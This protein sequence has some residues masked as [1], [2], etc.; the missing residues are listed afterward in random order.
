M[1]RT[2]YLNFLSFVFSQFCSLNLLT[3]SRILEI[4]SSAD[5]FGFP[6]NGILEIFMSLKTF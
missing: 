5:S 4:F 6:D 1:N 3:A 2:S